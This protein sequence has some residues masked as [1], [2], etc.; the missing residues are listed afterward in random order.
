MKIGDKLVY[1]FHYNISHEGI[2]FT[3]GKIYEIYGVG[4]SDSDLIDHIKIFK[5]EHEIDKLI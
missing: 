1:R 3:Y 2:N 4:D 5:R